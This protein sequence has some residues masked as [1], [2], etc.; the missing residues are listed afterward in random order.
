MN[1]KHLRVKGT[2]DELLDIAAKYVPPKK[3]A[4]ANKPKRKTTTKKKGAK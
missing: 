1:E 3:A 4:K 2:F